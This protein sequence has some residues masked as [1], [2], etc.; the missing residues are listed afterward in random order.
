MKIDSKI[1]LEERNMIVFDQDN[2]WYYANSEDE[3]YGT[4]DGGKTFTKIISYKKAIE[5]ANK[6]ARKDEYVAKSYGKGFST[7]LEENY[8]ENQHSILIVLNKDTV[9]MQVGTPK[10]IG[11]DENK[12]KG[13]LV[14]GIGLT[15]DIDPV[16]HM[17]MYIDAITGEVLGAGVFGD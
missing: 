15:D 16:T 10:G 1:I 6:E 2:T 13:Q 8:Y 4:G 7:E 12:I 5:I 14:W 9:L 11:I 17:T 3:Y